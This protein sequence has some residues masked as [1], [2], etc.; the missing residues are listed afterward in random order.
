M[1]N[2][3]Q[4]KKILSNID[5]VSRKSLLKKASDLGL[6]VKKGLNDSQLRKQIKKEGERQIEARMTNVIKTMVNEHKDRVFKSKY[7]VNSQGVKINKK[8]YKE[9]LDLQNKYNE[10]KDRILNRYI[11]KRDNEGSPIMFIELEFLKGMSIR[12][13][14][15]S[16]NITLNTSF[17][18]ENLIDSI[19]EGMDLKFYKQMIEDEIKNFR[20]TSVVTN[21]SRKFNNW[22]D[23]FLDTQL[24]TKNRAEELKKDY[25]ELNIIG[26]S[27]LNKE[28]ERWMSAVESIVNNPKKGTDVYNAIKDLMITQFGRD[29][30]KN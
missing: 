4:I 11:K 21:R 14:N 13:K 9:I 27:Q 15:A 26:R 22:I 2:R 1:L 12:H 30:L 3:L 10:K 19:T 16:E 28:L 6:E 18:K 7:E 17:R 25:I 24:I 5:K 20:I 8:D 29:Y 23:N